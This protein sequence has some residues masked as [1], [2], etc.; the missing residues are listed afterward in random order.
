MALVPQKE[1]SSFFVF[2]L[3]CYFELV[4]LCSYRIFTYGVG[5][6]K[7]SPIISVSKK[8][9]W[10]F[11]NHLGLWLQLLLTTFGAGDIEKVYDVGT[12]RCYTN[13]G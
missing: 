7:C 8:N 10:F 6:G 5:N 4:V 11:L 12:R 9:I 1:T 3:H 13:G 2:V